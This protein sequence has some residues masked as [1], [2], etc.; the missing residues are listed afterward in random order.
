MLHHI[1]IIVAAVVRLFQHQFLLNNRTSMT[2]VYSLNIADI[3]SFEENA[4][5]KA[6]CNIGRLFY[7]G[8]CDGAFDS[9]AIPG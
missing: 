8:R 1:T 6:P 2:L 3:L 9:S 4:A 5:I 7:Y